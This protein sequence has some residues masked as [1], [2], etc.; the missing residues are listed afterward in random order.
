LIDI[1]LEQII[2]NDDN[3]K[4]HCIDPKSYKRINKNTPKNIDLNLKAYQLLE[5]IDL[6][7]IEGM[8]YGTVLALISEVGLEG[9]K[10]FPSAKHFASWLR[11]PQTTR[12]AAERRSQAKCQ[13][14]A[15][16]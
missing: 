2:E 13:K 1:R 5:G 14:A 15:I 3:K 8:S 12:L 10:R 7:A 16:D 9:I 4:Q 6:L 11:W